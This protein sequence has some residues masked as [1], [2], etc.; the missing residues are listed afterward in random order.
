MALAQ[1]LL[2][3]LSLCGFCFGFASLG[4]RILRALHYDMPSDSDHVLVALAVGLVTTE[5]LLFLIQTTQHIREGCLAIVAFLCVLV[6]WEWKSVWVRTGAALR[7][8]VPTTPVGKFLLM[9]LGAVALVQFFAS[10]APLTG[11]DALHYH[12]TVQKQIL[13][14]GFHPLFSNSHSFLCGQHHLLILFGLALGSEHLALGFIFLGGILT[15]C[16][17]A[18]LASRW[19]GDLTVTAF[20][21][22]FLL[23]PVVFW[24]MTSSGS[25]DIYMA[26]LATT[27]VIM[28][29]QKKATPDWKCALL[30]GFIAGAIAG[31]KYTGCF[32]T[33]AVAIAFVIE[34]RTASGALL[35][36]V[37]AL[38]SGSW[39]YLRNLAWTGNPVFPFLSQRLS[40]QLVT[41]YAMAN[42]AKDTGASAGHYLWPA[43]PFIF[44][45]AVERNVPGFW[46]FFGPT[47]LAFAPLIFI[48]YRNER[49]W[50]V[51]V[52]VWLIS[53][54]AIFFFSGLSRFLL[55]IFPIA[56]SCAAAGFEVC[57]RERLAFP[58][59]VV[60]GLLILMLL[61]GGA[62]LA[63]Y[64]NKPVRVAVGLQDEEGYLE[65][66]APDYNLAQAVNK[67]LAKREDQPKVLVFFRHLYYLNV[68]FLNGDPGTSFE[69]DPERLKSASDWL[70]FF[71]RKGVGYVV[72]SPDYPCEFREP[73][74]G[75]EKTGILIPLERVSV[76]NFEGMRADQKRT[77]TQ[78]VI[79]KVGR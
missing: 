55:P 48:A 60:T 75:M 61:V 72:R 36:L 18:C 13:Q 50:R 17:L 3:F 42:L 25:P 2:T 22:S 67:L 73:L 43:F 4:M 32:V 52:Q 47:V 8:I 46:D 9:L 12:F 44:L 23:T 15:A 70:D 49:P 11:S 37:G 69:V 58:N 34:Y 76:E 5:I 21:M 19:T 74:E 63:L 10:Q 6:I 40:P 57:R 78:V 28:F 31:G 79:L 56:L 64:S 16:S 45:A 35:F 66:R 7:K 1:A 39:P 27:A 51:S 65:E 59:R 29:C 54:A 24:Q 14:L 77:A 62:G 38:V 33:A 53:S 20:T 71:Q 68:P 30:V 41:G 26:F